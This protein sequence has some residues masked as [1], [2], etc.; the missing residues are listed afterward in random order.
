MST[1]EDEKDRT[2]L[3]LRFSQG[4]WERWPIPGHNLRQAWSGPDGSFWA[5][6]VSTVVRLPIAQIDIRISATWRSRGGIAVFGLPI[7]QPIVLAD[8]LVVQ[9]FERARIEYRLNASGQV[10]SIT[11][12]RLAAELGYAEPAVAPDHEAR[13]PA[14]RAKHLAEA[15]PDGGHRL[16]REIALGYAAYVVLAKDDIEHRMHTNVGVRVVQRHCRGSA[17]FPRR[18]GGWASGLP[19]AFCIRSAGGPFD[20]NAV[21][22]RMSRWSLEKRP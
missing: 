16:V 20:E 4:K 12:G 13:W 18:M 22:G 7:S 21:L 10:T 1:A 17:H 6:T 14:R 11:F 3:V 15:A 5:H 8:G 9:Y 2:R 19:V